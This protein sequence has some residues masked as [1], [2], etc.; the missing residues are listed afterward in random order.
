M[1]YPSPLWG[2]NSRGVRAIQCMVSIY[3]RVSRRDYFLGPLSN[4]DFKVLPIYG[5]LNRG[6]LRVV[7]R[8]RPYASP[9]ER[10]ELPDE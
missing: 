10:Q 2:T 4:F 9:R 5:K 7:L 6:M 8:N 3:W 1:E